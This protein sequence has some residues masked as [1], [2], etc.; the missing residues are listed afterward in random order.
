MDS[1]RSRLARIGAAVVLSAVGFIAFDA[2]TQVASAAPPPVITTD[3]AAYPAPGSVPANCTGGAGGA[4][5]VQGYRAFLRR[6]GAPNAAPFVDPGPTG[7]FAT[8]RSLRRFQAQIQVGDEVVIRWSSWTANCESLPISFP[9]KATNAA[10]FDVTDDQALVREPNGPFNFPFCYSSGTESCPAAG[11]GFELSTV[12]PQLN[13]VCGYQLDVVIGGPL[14]TVGPHG[15]Y[16]GPQNRAQANQLGLGTFNPNGP[17]MLIDAANGA[18]PC[19]DTNR[20]VVDKQWAG[21]GTVPPANLPAGFQ[22]TVTS[23]VSQGDPTVLSTATCALSGG[24]FSCDYVDAAAP[25]VPQGG[26]LVNANSLLTVSETTFPGNTVDVTFPVGLSSEFVTCLP[27]GGACQ[28]TITNTPPPPPPDTTT[29]PTTVPPANTTIAP[30][31]TTTPTTSPLSI[32]NTLPATGSSDST[33]LV[34]FGLILV[35]VGAALV[36]VT[37]RRAG[38]Q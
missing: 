1:T 28:F 16:Y 23:S 3:Y 35:P 26:L 14:E 13:V 15:S 25:G 22:L 27:N 7:D 9:L 37:R 34:L 20:L 21:T 33:P 6:A 8:V 10:F 29:T 19:T 31:P 36:A 24:T 4:G 38:T 18:M 5:V 2:V 30:P 12:I 32:P 17:N 11:G